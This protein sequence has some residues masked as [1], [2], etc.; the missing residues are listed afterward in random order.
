MIIRYAAIHVSFKVSQHAGFISGMRPSNHKAREKLR[1]LRQ[2]SLN[3]K[4]IMFGN[5]VV[6]GPSTRFFFSRKENHTEKLIKLTSAPDMAVSL[7]RLR[8]LTI[9]PFFLK[10][11]FLPED[12]E[13]ATASDFLARIDTINVPIQRNRYFF[14][15]AMGN[16][17]NAR[18]L[19]LGTKYS[20]KTMKQWWNLRYLGILDVIDEVFKRKSLKVVFE[21]YLTKYKVC[22][23]QIKQGWKADVDVV[24]TKAVENL[25]VL[26]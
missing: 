6:T 18:S 7:C 25:L 11:L 17:W 20:N 2:L 22:L 8:L 23:V 10:Q 26:G 21:V 24:R 14:L 3:N 16:G 12:S 19:K 13:K 5:M 9:E 1:I 15:A 4:T